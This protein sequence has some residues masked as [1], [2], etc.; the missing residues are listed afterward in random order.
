[1]S[2]DTAAPVAPAAADSAGPRRWLR[3]NRAVTV[4][5]VVIVLAVLGLSVLTARNATRGGALDPDNPHP[6]GAQAVA[7]VLSRHGV[8]VT[9]VRR[10]TQLAGTSIDRD[11]TVMVTSA[12]NLGRA[13]AAQLRRHSSSAGQVVLADPG[14]TL[15]EA[16]GLPIEPAD[17]NVGRLTAAGCDDPL[18][19][20][21]SLDVRPSTGYRGKGAAVEECFRGRGSQPG[22]LLVRVD[23]RSPVYAVGGTDLFTN[24][25][26]DRAGNAAA[27][28]RLL[29]AHGRL[30]WYVPDSRDVA[31]GDTG[32]FAAQLPRG[33]VP[34]LWLVAAAV[35]A[36]M[37]WRGRRLGP[38][39]VEPL[40]VTVK[41]V[42]STQGRGRLYRRV[43][44]RPHASAVLR[45]ATMRRL[46]TLLRLPS[47]SNPWQ[48]ADAAA[49]MIG[50]DPRA[51]LEVLVDRPVP[52]DA[53]L[54]RLAADLNALEKEVH[55]A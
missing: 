11:T 49:R 17:A 20:D 54:V 40:P 51:V 19:G 24:D 52:D 55:D 39:V 35:L 8:D 30:V 46:V 5:V 26:V 3:R 41:A 44:D 50:R 1:M 16:F 28:L 15:L 13:T 29:G 23:K 53:A 47:D 10:A 7:R 34:A 6:S 42:E 4:I 38:L 45:A 31:A 9:V 2:I 12:Q 36:T 21:L 25:R 37:L 14:P 32:S 18:V 22:T 43:G 48:V 33:L 27:A